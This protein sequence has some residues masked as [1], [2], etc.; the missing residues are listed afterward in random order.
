MSIVDVQHSCT[1]LNLE[2]KM[3]TDLLN[4]LADELVP[5]LEKRGVV[6]RR[7]PTPPS[8]PPSGST[9]R[10]GP[11]DNAELASFLDPVHLGDSVLLRAELFFNELATNGEVMSLDL[12]N[13]LGLLGPRSIPANLTIPLKKSARR[14]GLKDPWTGD[15]TP[16]GLRTVTQPRRHC[17]AHAQGD[18]G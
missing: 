17:G 9:R 12:S 4:A 18:R 8:A 6:I 1:P 14:L 16:D 5:L 13:M 3:T 15:E 7:A 2:A 11:Y 10:G